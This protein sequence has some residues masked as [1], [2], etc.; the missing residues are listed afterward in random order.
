[1]RGQCDDGTELEEDRGERDRPGYRHG[2]RLRFRRG[3]DHA[4]LRPDRS[5]PDGRHGFRGA[6]GRKDRCPGFG[7]RECLH[8]APQS[9]ARRTSL[10]LAQE[11][12][13]VLAR[14]DTSMVPSHLWGPEVGASVLLMDYGSTP[15]LLLKS[16]AFTNHHVYWAFLGA[17]R[18][19]N[20]G[21]TF[22]Y[23]TLLDR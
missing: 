16:P 6:K 15:D 12:I 22:I 8:Q 5:R 23:S 11:R 19:L 21:N 4:M 14:V 1:M 10:G 9:V 13:E 3:V 2:D 18:G 20:V 7:E 17:C